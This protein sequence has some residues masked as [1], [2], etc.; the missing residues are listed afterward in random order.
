MGRPRSH[1][2]GAGHQVGADLKACF[3]ATDSEGLSMW[4]LRG[5]LLA[6]VG[7][8]VCLATAP[9]QGEDAA[10]WAELIDRHIEAR[11]D[12]EGLTRAPQAD[13]A[14]FLRRLMLD[15]H[16]RV[17]SADVTQRFLDSRDEH[18]REQ[19]I[20]EALDNPRLGEHFA[21]LWRGRL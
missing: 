14:E 5:I 3:S 2:L 6:N 12:A 18:K 21:D 16:G 4:R 13:D 10:A 17:P 15:L 19:L 8:L 1:R 20:D 9:A 7:L 11:L